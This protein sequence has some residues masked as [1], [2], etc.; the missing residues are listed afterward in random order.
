V[1]AEFNKPYSEELIQDYPDLK[2]GIWFGNQPFR[3][4]GV[5]SYDNKAIGK[6]IKFEKNIP[7][8]ATL[9]SSIWRVTSYSTLTSGFI[10]T[11]MKGCLQ[12]SN[13]ILGQVST[14]ATVYNVSAPL[15]DED[16]DSL[17]FTIAAPTFESDGDKKQGLYDLVLR[18]DVAKC[19]WG[20]SLLNT[21]AS[22][23]VLNPDGTTQV[24]T[25]TFKVLNGYVYFRAAGF[26]F[27][28]PK[29]KVSV[30]DAAP[31]PKATTAASKKMS[32][33]TCVKGKASKKVTAVKPTCPTGYKKK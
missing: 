33:I 2:T 8:K 4:I 18:E 31:T 10:Y 27:S 32:T 1:I 25:T 20:K 13:G 11:E 6:W 3:G 7:K 29:I 12:A 21:R 19:L 15:W 14:N 16:T 26:H 24:A 5:S 30:I 17:S 28:V 9:D 23:E 22:I